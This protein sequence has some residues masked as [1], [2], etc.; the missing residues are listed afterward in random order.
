MAQTA[1]RG[2]A[3]QG[4][5]GTAH[6]GAAGTAHQGAAGAA[7]QRARVC[8][9]LI[10]APDKLQPLVFRVSCAKTGFHFCRTRH[11][12]RFWPAMLAR[13]SPNFPPPP[14]WPPAPATPW[15]QGGDG[16]AIPDPGRQPFRHRGGAGVGRVSPGNLSR[17]TSKVTGAVRIGQRA[18]IGTTSH[19][20]VKGRVRTG[21]HLAVP[22]PPACGAWRAATPVYPSALD[23]TT[24]GAVW[25]C[26]IGTA[27][28]NL[29]RT[30]TVIKPSQMCEVSVTE[31]L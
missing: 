1:R 19:C 20:A 17:C 23:Q 21:R 15:H 27:Q 22:V 8:P 12:G 25:P 26:P 16:C 13:M 29:C 30:E 10:E 9:T 28:C 6:Q 18:S 14:H 31:R 4:T 7:A 24:K 3:H 11:T 2:T 5:A